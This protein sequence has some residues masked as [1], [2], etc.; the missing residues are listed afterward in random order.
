MKPA[1]L[2]KPVLLAALVLATTA[3]ES[4][5]GG[6]SGVSNFFESSFSGKKK[7]GLVRVDELL[8]KIEQVHVET[9]VSKETVRESMRALRTLVAPD[10][11]GDALGSYDAFVKAIEQGEK[12]AVALRKSVEP[13]E[14]TAEQVFSDWAKSLESFSNAEMRERSQLRLENTRER[15]EAIISAVEPAQ[16]AFDALNRTLRDHALFLSH[17]FN[18]TAVTELEGEVEGLMKHAS[19]LDKRFDA[20]LKAAK[21]YVRSTALRGQGGDD[22]A[23]PDEEVDTER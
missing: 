5:S 22:E 1:S 11:G 20:T 14:K 8:L 10:F 19:Q 13:M 15:Y 3:C 6:V 12:Q 23:A 17:D 4:V 7:D 21:R 16:W 2:K 9:E 18:A